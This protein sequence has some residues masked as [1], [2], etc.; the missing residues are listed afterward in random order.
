MEETIDHC[1]IYDWGGVHGHYPLQEGGHLAEATCGGCGIRARRS[2]IH[3]VWQSRMYS[4]CEESYAPFAYQT[5]RFTTSFYLETKWIIILFILFVSFAYQLQTTKL[6]WKVVLCV[7][8]QVLLV[9][10]NPKP[11]VNICTLKPYKV[12]HNTFLFKPPHLLNMLVET[13]S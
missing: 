2:N 1:I 12:I 8:M 13:C 6:L 3:H 4:T 5:H 10:N 9:E 7:I 11:Y